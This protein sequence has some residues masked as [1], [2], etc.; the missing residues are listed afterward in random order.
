MKNFKPGQ[1]VVC[2]SSVAWAVGK[3]PKQNEVVT[4]KSK[5]LDEYWSFVEYWDADENYYKEVY[6]EPLVE[7]SVLSEELASISE[8]VTV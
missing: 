4:V 7:D 3:G 1:E 8:P 6:F 2:T 5:G